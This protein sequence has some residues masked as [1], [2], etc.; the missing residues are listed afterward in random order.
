MNLKRTKKIIRKK[1][2]ELHSLLVNI[3]F[4]YDKHRSDSYF[5]KETGTCQIEQKSIKKISNID[6]Y[7]ETI[8]SYFSNFILFIYIIAILIIQIPFLIY[9]NISSYYKCKKK[10]VLYTFIGPIIGP[11]YQ[12][13]TIKGLKL[14]V[15][16]NDHPPPHFHVVTDKYN[17][18][19]EISS[20]DFLGCKGNIEDRHLKSIRKWHKENK[21]ILLRAWKQTRP[22]INTENA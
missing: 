16:T 11:M 18:K 20:C 13:D 19:F 6:R 1:E 22:S 4:E 17:A 12:V 5:N 10:G 21:S 9:G 8:K 7:K 3:D 14:R 2:K 15:Y